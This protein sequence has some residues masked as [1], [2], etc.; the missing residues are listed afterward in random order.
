MV[1]NLFEHFALKVESI[2]SIYNVHC[3]A[4]DLLQ[5]GL[6]STDV[7]PQGGV[8]L[9][10]HQPIS[11][12]CRLWL[13]I[14]QPQCL[15]GEVNCWADY[16]IQKDLKC[17]ISLYLIQIRE[18][19]KKSLKQ[20]WSCGHVYPP[21][22]LLAEVLVAHNLCHLTQICSPSQCVWGF[23][24]ADIQ[25]VAECVVALLGCVS[26]LLLIQTQLLF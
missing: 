5:V 17:F 3:E 23:F 18:K 12:L 6:K 1:L 4:T 16:Q 19:Q 11:I 9:L 22:S 25:E 14:Q 10:I 8:C 20:I 13:W 21:V 7:E 2:D 24:M 26:S 15:M